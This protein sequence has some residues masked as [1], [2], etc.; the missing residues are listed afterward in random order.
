MPH[1]FIAAE[2]VQHINYLWKYW[3]FYFKEVCVTVL[4][5]D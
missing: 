3:W 4:W 1:I 2:L 5:R